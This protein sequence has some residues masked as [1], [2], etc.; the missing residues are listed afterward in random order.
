MV[1]W[2]E[3]ECCTVAVE[4]CCDSFGWRERLAGVV[5]QICAVVVMPLS[6]RWQIRS[7]TVLSYTR[8]FSGNRWGTTAVPR[9]CA[10]VGRHLRRGIVQVERDMHRRREASARARRGIARVRGGTVQI[11]RGIAQMWR[12]TV[13]VQGRCII[14]GGIV[15][16]Q[17][18][19]L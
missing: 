17:R 19:A 1:R 15:Q 11:Q 9:H 5:G 16:A 8:L 7:W 10:S 14:A 4:G 2:W 12:G 6:G 18:G 3:A 13:Q